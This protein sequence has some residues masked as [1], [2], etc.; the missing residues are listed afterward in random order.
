MET[1]DGRANEAMGGGDERGKELDDH[2]VGVLGHAFDFWA[3]DY[4]HGLFHFRGGTD[5]LGLINTGA[6]LCLIGAKF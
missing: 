5:S 1:G 2:E 4:K 6:N 3:L